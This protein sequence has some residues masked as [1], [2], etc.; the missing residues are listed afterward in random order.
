MPLINATYGNNPRFAAPRSYWNEI[1]VFFGPGAVVTL[2][3]NV[4]HVHENFTGGFIDTWITLDPKFAPW[5]SDRWT[6][7][8]I[9]IDQVSFLDG[10]GSPIYAPC[11]IGFNL[12]SAAGHFGAAIS[13]VGGSTTYFVELPPAPA[14][15]WLAPPPP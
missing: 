14:D 1:A 11:V 7:D 13:Y 15:Y 8:H 6:L 5:S 3:G 12:N 2:S 4:I 9:F 10:G